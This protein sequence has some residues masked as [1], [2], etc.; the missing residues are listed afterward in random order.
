[1]IGTLNVYGKLAKYDNANDGVTRND[2][3][4]VWSSIT[5]DDTDKTVTWSLSGL[6]GLEFGKDAH[7]VVRGATPLSDT[8]SIQAA[9]NA[10]EV[11]WEER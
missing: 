1:M 4:L 3:T 6:G 11:L 8:A 9:A 2:T 7:V 5:A 10:L